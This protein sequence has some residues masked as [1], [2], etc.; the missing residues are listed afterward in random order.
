MREPNRQLRQARERTASPHL[1][2]QPLSRQELAELLNIAVYQATERICA[3]DA[4]YIGKL[5]RGTVRWPHADYRAALRLI[6]HA[7]TD[8]ELGFRPH[9]RPT[10]ATTNLI[11]PGT[12]PRPAALPT[13]TER[14]TPRRQARTLRHERELPADA[15]IE[16]LWT[17]SGLAA[18]FE[19]VAPMTG[20]SWERRQFLALSGVALATA[21]QEWLLADPARIVASLAGKRVD[22]GVV[23]DLTITLDALRRLDDKLGGQAVHGMVTE[24]LRLVVRLLRHTSYTEA[25]GRSLYGIAA[26][27]A[28]LAGWTSYDAGHHGTAQRYYLVGLRAAHEA[29]APGIAANILRCMADQA[30]TTGDPRSAVDLLRSARAGARGRLTATE[31]AVLFAGLARSHG[32][33]H[34]QYQAKKAIDA[35]YQAIQTANPAEDPPY[36]YWAA[37]SEIAF[38]AGSSLLYAD[39]PHAA[40]P[41][42]RSSVEQTGDDMPRELLEVRVR[43]ATA[44][45]EA[46]DPDQAV[47]IAREAITTAAV[48]SAIVSTRLAE[49][50]QAL[51]AAGHPEAE[52][53]AEHARS[54]PGNKDM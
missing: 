34:D 17:S 11:P 45:T 9:R 28:R 24:Q 2:G 52:D 5:E 40:I 35:A 46:G 1:P 31:Q 33:A 20:S 27:L 8:A 39:Q 4:H 38:A 18:A 30:R 54:I 42:L 13:G 36:I 7:A 6:L 10:A 44:Y 48:P 15:G 23:T 3:V 29:D 32:R 19:E 50:C 41:H 14:R 22:A 43:L 12:G 37:P 51:D 49:L 26:E 16:Q 47:A 53:L 25:D 21:A